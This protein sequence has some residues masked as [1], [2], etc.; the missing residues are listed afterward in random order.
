MTNPNDVPNV[1]D[2]SERL[3]EAAQD[4]EQAA[5]DALDGDPTVVCS[6]EECLAHADE[7]RALAKEG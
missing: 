3:E 5:Q 4:W 2:H 7:C 1:H 6:Y